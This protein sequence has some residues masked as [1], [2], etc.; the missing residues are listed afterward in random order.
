M[1]IK[2]IRTEHDHA[3]ALKR[4]EQLWKSVQGTPAGDE[5]DALVT[6]VEAFESK[7]YPM[8]TPASP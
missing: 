4:I 5:L 7:H 1:D 2:P 6:L 3:V 8:D